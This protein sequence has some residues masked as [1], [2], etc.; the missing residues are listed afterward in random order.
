MSSRAARG[1]GGVGDQATVD[2]VGDAA[3]EA[4]KCFSSAFSFALF[5]LKVVAAGVIGSGLSNGDDIKGSVE[6]SITATV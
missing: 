2:G 5:A 4:S 1:C 3:L 6:P